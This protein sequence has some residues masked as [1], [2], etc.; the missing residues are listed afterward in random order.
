M[1]KTYLNE[2]V[3]VLKSKKGDYYLKVTED[4]ETFKKFVENLTP[5]SAIF[6]QKQEDKLNQ[7]A[8]AGKITHE[9][10]EEL[11]EKTSFIIFNGTYSYENN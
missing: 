2:V 3:Q 10:A 8:E 1:A 5:G 4:G 7:L 9:R 6:F 11:K